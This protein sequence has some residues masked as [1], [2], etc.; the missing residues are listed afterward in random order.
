MCNHY[1]VKAHITNKAVLDHMWLPRHKH[2]DGMKKMHPRKRTVNMKEAVRILS[3]PAH[4]PR[5]HREISLMF[6]SC[7][8]RTDMSEPEWKN[9][10]SQR[11]VW[12]RPLDSTDWWSNVSARTRRHA[13]RAPSWKMNGWINKIASHCWNLPTASLTNDKKVQVQVII[14]PRRVQYCYWPDGR[15]LF[16]AGSKVGTCYTRPASRPIFPINVL[17]GIFSFQCS[18]INY[19]WESLF[20]FNT[21]QWLKEYMHRICSSTVHWPL[22]F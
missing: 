3:R 15:P 11:L 5:F 8:G 7:S 18:L 13:V 20:N 14:Q 12:P 21:S 4:Y 17:F 2:S 9:K 1:G 16:Q 10:T 19:F 6:S 22:K